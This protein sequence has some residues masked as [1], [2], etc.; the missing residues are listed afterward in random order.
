MQEQAFDDHNGPRGSRLRFE[1]EDEIVDRVD[2]GRLALPIALR[3][4]RIEHTS[5][6]NA[7]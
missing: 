1:V 2:P 3:G 6:I 4:Q 7:G 5:L